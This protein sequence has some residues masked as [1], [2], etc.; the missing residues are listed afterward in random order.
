MGINANKPSQ[1]WTQP[2]HMPAPRYCIILW[3]S[4]TRKEETWSWQA[5][6][7]QG[8]PQVPAPCRSYIEVPAKQAAGFALALHLPLLLF[9]FL[10]ITWGLRE[11]DLNP[12]PCFGTAHSAQHLKLGQ[13]SWP[14]ST[15]QV[16]S[17]SSTVNQPCF[18]KKIKR[19]NQTSLKDLFNVLSGL[20]KLLSTEPSCLSSGSQTTLPSAFAHFLFAQCNLKLCFQESRSDLTRVHPQS[21]LGAFCFPFAFCLPN[22]LPLQFCFFLHALEPSPIFQPHHWLHFT[23]HTKCKLP[24]SHS[25][26]PNIPSSPF[27]PSA[28]SQAPNQLLSFAHSCGSLTFHPCIKSALSYVPDHTPSICVSAEKSL[29]WDL[30]NKL[31]NKL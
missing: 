27:T 6:L 8:Q 21:S 10:C 18:I 3:K 22:A 9:H 25:H 26:L 19:K 31:T 17:K 5:L 16:R 11:G 29:W 30:S 28:P 23:Y 14:N 7:C 2:C 24:A 1:S 20:L 12:N 15:S 13:Q 4:G